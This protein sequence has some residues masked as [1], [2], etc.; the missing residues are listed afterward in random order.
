MAAMLVLIGLLL[1]RL[2]SPRSVL[3]TLWISPSVD[4]GCAAQ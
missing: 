3:P 4:G 2:Q 1:I